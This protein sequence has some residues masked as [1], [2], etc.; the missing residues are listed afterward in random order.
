MKA[1][2]WI[3]VGTV[4]QELDSYFL[5]R[6]PALVEEGPIFDAAWTQRCRLMTAPAGQVTLELFVLM[7]NADVSFNAQDGGGL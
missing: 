3:P 4:A 7:R 1:N 5:G 6:T 2:L